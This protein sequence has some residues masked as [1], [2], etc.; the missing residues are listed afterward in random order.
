MKTLE[1]TKPFTFARGPFLTLGAVT[2]LGVA[3]ADQVT[4]YLVMEKILRVTAGGEAEVLPL[5]PGLNFV[6]VWNRGVSFGMFDSGD[7]RAAYALC[8]LSFAICAP[9]ALWM[10][11]TQKKLLAVALALVVGG[12]A[13]NVVD[14]LRFGAVAD[15]IDVYV[16][17]WHW[18]AFNVADSAIV[19]GA[20]L[21][22]LDAFCEKEEKKK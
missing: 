15:F 17:N 7:A 4:K 8:A 20:G 22:M 12:A 14:R 11:Q 3:V 10:A 2:A 5:I 6:M 16:K 21:L 18:P 9:L 1:M 13:G 19:I